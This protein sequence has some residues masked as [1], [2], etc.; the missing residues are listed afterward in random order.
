MLPIL[1]SILVPASIG[2]FFVSIVLK[3]SKI[4][5]RNNLF[6]VCLGTGIGFGITSYLFFIWCVIFGPACRGYFIIEA[7][8]LASL[9]IIHC[10]TSR[11]GL[12]GAGGKHDAPGKRNILHKLLEPC[13]YLSAIGAAVT[14]SILSLLNPHGS[15]DA[16]MTWNLHAKFIFLGGEHWKGIFAPALAWSHPDYPFLIPAAIARCWIFI[17]RGTTVIPATVSILFT[18]ATAGTLT[19]ALII[20]RGRSQGFLAGMVLLATPFFITQGA[21]QYADIPAAFFY[22][23]TVVLLCLW[24]NSAP[25]AN[26]LPL[27][28]GLT[29]GFS[30][31]TKNEGLLFLTAIIVARAF[32]R[33]IIRR[34]RK[35]YLK[36]TLYFFAGAI[37]IL[38]LIIYFK[39]ALATHSDLLSDRTIG[40][41][42]K[43]LADL[44]KCRLI[45]SEFFNTAMN[46]GQ[47]RG[48]FM[49]LLFFCALLFGIKVRVKERP[50]FAAILAA[51]FMMLAGYFFIFLTTPYGVE[52]HMGTALDRLFLQL[53]P[54]IVFIYFLATLA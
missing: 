35:S 34:E 43:N 13:F 24:D 49:P 45:L 46:F 40:L 17:G 44:P 30:G 21:A 5:S 19:A 39:S 23:A 52:W 7:L 53:W 27:L 37:P 50:V 4:L 47:W 6:K 2:F 1:F 36:E 48:P 28:A 38:L 29:A 18:L 11:K 25:A 12:P 15:W 41:A 31:W 20:M 26:G 8:L 42:V 14:L 10:S 33:I 3:D 9:I 32:A 16:W 51:A 22:L 54:C